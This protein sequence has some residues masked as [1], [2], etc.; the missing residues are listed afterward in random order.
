MHQTASFLTKK[1]KVKYVDHKQ[2][3][4]TKKKQTNENDQ[5]N[6]KHLEMSQIYQHRKYPLNHIIFALQRFSINLKK[7]RKEGSFKF[8]LLSKN[9]LID[10]I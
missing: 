10:L 9:E 7:R 4:T 6:E 5:S 8:K 2:Y 1:T 3:F